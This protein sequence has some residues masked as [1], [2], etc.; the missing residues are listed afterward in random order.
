MG[1]LY[2]DDGKGNGSYCSIMV[3]YWDNG[4]ENGNYYTIVG[5]FS[6]YI[7]FRGKD[8]GLRVEGL[9]LH[10]KSLNPKPQ[11]VKLKSKPLKAK[12]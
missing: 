11:T 9:G 10:T 2:W 3:F 7:G 1:G 5:C 8:P 4:R 6:C 12:P